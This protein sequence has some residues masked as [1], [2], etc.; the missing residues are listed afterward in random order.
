MTPSRY[1]SVCCSGRTWTVAGLVLVILI[2]TLYK[3]TPGILIWGGSKSDEPHYRAEDLGELMSFPRLA[4]HPNPD[5]KSNL[6]RFEKARPDTY[7]KHINATEKLLSE[8]VAS[9]WDHRF[10]IDC[11]DYDSYR[12]E[13]TYSETCHFKL[14]QLGEECFK[15][16]FGYK[17]GKPCILFNLERIFRWLPAPY[18]NKSVPDNIRDLWSMYS[19]TLKCCGRDPVS[20][21][22][23]GP[24][25]Y[26]PKDGFHFKYFPFTGQHTWR[27]PLVF[28]RF[29]GPAPAITLFIECRIYARNI[30]HNNRL[31]TGMVSFELLVD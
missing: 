31:D 28:V 21:D 12:P 4:F 11:D 5:G 30:K 20:N 15:D 27:T 9:R 22:S 13:E 23:I 7:M 6:I 8:Y 19:I 29:A 18:N 26:Y 10:W 17:S 24:I 2:I 3:L 14:S 25:E 16:N 1:G